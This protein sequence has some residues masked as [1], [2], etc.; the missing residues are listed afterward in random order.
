MARLPAT[1]V[2]LV[3]TDL[4][5]NLRDYKRLIAL[6][7]HEEA[8]GN[9]PILLLTGDLVHGPHPEFNAPGMWP[10]Y[11][12][13]AYVD[14]SRALLT[15]FESFTRTARAFAL[16]GNHDHAHVGGPVVAKFHDDEAAVFEAG[17]GADRDRLCA[18]MATYPLIAVAPCGAVFTHAAPYATADSLE[19]FEA[20]DYAGYEGRSIQQ[21]YSSD[22]VGAL[23]WARCARPHQARRLLAATSLDG[24]PNAFVAFGHDV[25]R[26]G[27]EVVGDEQICVSTSYGLDTPQKTY[28]RLDL[29]RR[30]DSVHDLRPG[31]ELLSLY[32]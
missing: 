28:L 1:G 26:E 4:H 18:F 32:S 24:A 21:M 25:V 3:S 11:L 19:A 20:L 7:E 12:G 27:Y 14:E 15:H 13:T 29:S 2:L 8:P 17:L 22:A 31:H 30:Y 5:G 6:Y 9:R 16:M 23:L 10:D